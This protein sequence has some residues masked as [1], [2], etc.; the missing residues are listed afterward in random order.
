MGWGGV[1]FT[2]GLESAG[3]PIPSE[4]IMPLSGWMLVREDGLGAGYVY[5]AALYGT[6]GNL[7]GSALAYWIGARGGRGLLLKYGKYVLLTPED[8]ERAERWFARYGGPTVFFSRLL[9]GI[10]TYIS[11]PA[12][13]AGMNFSRFLLYTLA[14]SYPWCLGL[15][16]GGYLLGSRWEQIRE[17]FRPFELPLFLIALAFIALFIYRRV[18]GALS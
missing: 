13:I 1:V 14:G 7:W 2:M 16:Y 8:L 18:R 12:G 10:R 15:A 3:I 11:F 17:W 6:L 4:V 9:P 5:L